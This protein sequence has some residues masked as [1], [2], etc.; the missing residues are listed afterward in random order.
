MVRS[1]KCDTFMLGGGGGRGLYIKVNSLLLEFLGTIF[2]YGQTGTG[3]TYTM[4][5]TSDK[6]INKI[7]EGTSTIT[8]VEILQPVPSDSKTF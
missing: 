7:E 1:T 8:R 4:E 2:A 6:I 5:G 3:K